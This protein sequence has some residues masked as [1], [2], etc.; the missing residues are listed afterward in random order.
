[1]TAITVCPQCN[2]HFKITQTQSESHQGL[3]RCGHCKH[4]FNA[5]E[6][7]YSQP[8]QLD[9]P[10]MLDDIADATAMYPV[11]TPSGA[12]QKEG[13][14]SISPEAAARM[15]NDFSHLADVYVSPRKPLSSKQHSRLWTFGVL[16]I[17]LV[18]SVQLVYFLRVEIASRFPAIKPV[19]SLICAEVHCTLPLPQK[20]DLLS[21]ESSEL[22]ADPALANVITL[23]ALIRS[24]A[25]YAMGY[26]NI[27]L[28]LTDLQDN[29]LV[30]RN[31]T[32]P[33]YL[34]NADDKLRGFPP[35]REVTLN[36]HLNTTD[37]KAAGYKL[38]LF[39]P[40]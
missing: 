34:Q 35:N 29:L 31:F 33:D 32:P 20:I 27:E 28:T 37:L 39:Y 5:V 25:P 14:V 21:I 13:L 26:P 6:N 38:F 15:S 3:V 18:L 24:R 17:T 9:L 4:V 12:V 2:T 7:S 10:L 8:E 16:L 30:R 23:H 40:G 36:L 19:I 1:M 22:E 11:Y